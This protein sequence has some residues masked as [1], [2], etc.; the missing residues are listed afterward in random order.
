MRSI[1]R[2]RTL[3]AHRCVDDVVSDLSLCERGQYITFLQT[4]HLAY[5]TILGTMPVGHWV[6]ALLRDLLA[7]LESDLGKL[8]SIVI[9][10]PMIGLTQPLQPLAVAYV[11]CG[12]HFG[13]TILRK[14]WSKST[15]PAVRAAGG[16]LADTTLKHG[17]QRL[18]ELLAELEKPAEE[19][20][21]LADDADRTFQLFLDCLIVAKQKVVANGTA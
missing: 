21:S 2:Q 15:D 6:S 13:K 19:F 8:D 10:K 11:I 4:H 20:N 1:L 12:S 3:A 14:R 17:W 7:K 5:Q 9:A 16:F 18:M